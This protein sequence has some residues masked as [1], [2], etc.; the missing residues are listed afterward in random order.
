[1]FLWRLRNAISLQVRE[2]VLESYQNRVQRFTPPSKADWDKYLDCDLPG[3]A[4]RRSTVKG[5]LEIEIL[6]PAEEAVKKHHESSEAVEE[7]QIGS[8]FCLKKRRS[9]LLFGPPGTSKTS[10]AEAVA[11]RLGWPFV[12]LS[13]SDFLK[14]GLP[15]IYDRVNE[16]FDDLMD[17]FGVVILFDEMDALVQ[18]ARRRPR[19]SHPGRRKAPGLLDHQHVAETPHAQEG[20]QGDLLHGYQPPARLRPGDQALRPV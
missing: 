9:A 18:S 16:V 17:L 15:G 19:P 3:Q 7:E 12:G 13:P 8:N 2:I 11:R 10:L 4:G 14:G 1:M 20:G 5:M 6:K